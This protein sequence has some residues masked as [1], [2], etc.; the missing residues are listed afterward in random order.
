MAPWA[1]GPSGST[2]GITSQNI[3]DAFGRVAIL[4]RW[5]DELCF[6]ENL[7]AAPL[8]QFQQ[9]RGLCSALEDR[10]WRLGGIEA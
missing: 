5:R 8:A 9:R 1:G 4:R 6:R 10:L 7:T 3:R 2:L